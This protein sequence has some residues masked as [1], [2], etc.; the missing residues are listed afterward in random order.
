MEAQHDA[1]VEVDDARAHDHRPPTLNS[2]A[3]A[4]LAP[5]RCGRSGCW[6]A[7]VTSCVALAHVAHVGRTHPHEPASVGAQVV[8]PGPRRSGPRRDGVHRHRVRPPSEAPQRRWPLVDL[9]VCPYIAPSTATLAVA[10]STPS[11]VA[12]G[13]Y[14]SSSSVAIWPG[15]DLPD[16][17]AST[18]G[19]I[20]PRSARTKTWPASAITAGRNS[21]GM[22]CRPA[23]AVMRP[24][25]PS[26]P[27]HV[28]ATGH[29]ATGSHRASQYPNVVSIRSALAPRQ[30][31]A[32]HRMRIT[33]SLQAARPRDIQ[34]TS[35]PI[36]AA[37][38]TSTLKAG[39]RR[40]QRA[41][42]G[43]GQR[44]HRGVA[45][46]PSG[47]APRARTPC[48]GRVADEPGG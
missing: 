40:S 34:G 26:H 1:R 45:P 41:M 46:I 4:P 48:P 9:L 23:E 13:R 33:Q 47:S 15:P 8:P 36:P 27:V 14:R 42:S 31:R 11:C 24:A 21:A 7:A 5:W 32:D 16:T 3:A 2:S 19:S 30:Q 10:R 28:P 35:T 29:R 38:A 22:L 37:A 12:T 17:A 25:A 6:R 44:Q 20:W 18:R 43:Q 39:L